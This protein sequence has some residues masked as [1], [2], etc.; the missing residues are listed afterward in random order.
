MLN[1]DVD[2]P[3]DEFIVTPL[4]LETSLF[5]RTP[6]SRREHSMNL[7]D[8]INHL[9]HVVHTPSRTELYICYASRIEKSKRVLGQLKKVVKGFKQTKLTSNNVH[10]NPAFVP[11][12]N[13]FPE[14]IKTNS[15]KKKV[16]SL[17]E[18]FSKSLMIFYRDL[19]SNTGSFFLFLSR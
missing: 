11:L 9:H 6:N 4:T 17:K 10:L 2:F 15:D 12:I 16:K 7:H 1:Y 5:Q 8:N 18:S 13:Y 19:N 14:D 3:Q